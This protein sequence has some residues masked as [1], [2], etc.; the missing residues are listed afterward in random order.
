MTT[1]QPYSPHHMF[2]QQQHNH[3]PVVQNLYAGVD[4]FRAQTPRTYPSALPPKPNN[5]QANEPNML[6]SARS[7]LELLKSLCEQ[8]PWTWTDGMLLVGCLHYAL[9]EYAQALHWFSRIVTEEPK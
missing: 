4:Q 9:E 5:F 7:S 3:T 6:D 2:Q 1:G 8:A